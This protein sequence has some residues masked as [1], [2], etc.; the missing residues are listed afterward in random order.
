M[1]YT[2]IHGTN[3]LA[4]A[5]LPKTGFV[6]ASPYFLINKY[7]L[8][9]LGGEVVHS[10]YVPLNSGY[11]AFGALETIPIGLRDAYTLNSI[12]EQYTSGAMPNR[13]ELIKN[14]HEEIVSF[15]AGCFSRLNMILVYLARAKQ[16]G[17]STEDIVTIEE[18]KT[19][20]RDIDAM[21]QYFHFL[22]LLGTHINVAEQSL[23]D[24]FKPQNAVL[25]STFLSKF[26]Y[27][28]ITE[29]ITTNK[30]NVEYL[31]NHRD[32]LSEEELQPLID[33]LAL[34]GSHYFSVNKDI[35]Q[36]SDLE[37][38]WRGKTHCNDKDFYTLSMNTSM[39]LATFFKEMMQG[40][41]TANYFKELH[42]NIIAFLNALKEKRSELNMLFEKPAQN[43]L[44]EEDS[45]F[46]EAP[47]PLVFIA[48]NNK[49]ILL[50]DKNKA[51]YRAYQPLVVGKDIQTIATNTEKNQKSVSDFLVKNGLTSINVI[52]FDKLKECRVSKIAAEFLLVFREQY[53]HKFK[54]TN[55]TGLMKMYKI[56]NS[57]QSSFEKLKSMI[58]IARVK[59]TPGFSFWYS[60]SH[61][62]GKGRHKNVMYLY[63][64][65]SQLKLDADDISD[66]WVRLQKI[67]VM[68]TSL[69]FIHGDLEKSSDNATARL[70]F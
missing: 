29:K 60:N 28:N 39:A 44:S 62:L 48:D 36:A 10:R 43:I 51:E 13:E 70:S 14:I 53:S 21:I 56:V 42:I 38:E 20:N 66:V 15:K 18:I 57:N 27:F 40:L 4:L 25:W 58:A 34:P 46:S 5:L 45:V 33:L 24:S 41:M 67:T 26:T 32:V 8:A 54:E 65:L 37:L 35:K 31:Y 69:S 30:I 7:Q 64:E 50:Y 6:L 52:T 55:S 17:I 3:S 11:V 2:Y 63:K 16:I 49:Q 1:S 19:L 12:V 47:F 9:P 61:I 68:I 22:L 23:V 59:T